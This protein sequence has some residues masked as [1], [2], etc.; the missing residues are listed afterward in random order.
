MKFWG[1]TNPRQN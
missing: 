1:S